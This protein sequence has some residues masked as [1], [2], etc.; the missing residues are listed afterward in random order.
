MA[1]ILSIGLPLTSKQEC[2]YQARSASQIG[3]SLGD[4]KVYVLLYSLCNVR[5]METY[6]ERLVER[7]GSRHSGRRE[8]KV[9]P[10]CTCSLMAAI[11]LTLAPLTSKQE[12]I[13]QTQSASQIDASLGSY[14][15]T[16][17]AGNSWI[18]G[19]IS[20]HI[21]KSM[22]Q[23]L[24]LETITCG[25]LC[26]NRLDEV[27]SLRLQSCNTLQD[28]LGEFLI[29]RLQ[30]LKLHVTHFAGADLCVTVPLPWVV[31]G[32]ALDT[33]GCITYILK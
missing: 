32:L 3:A 29:M 26:R 6:N 9:R 4:L 21:F 12:C 19:Q 14:V 22:P 15:P 11:L 18:C 33:I 24:T 1:A 10:S 20:T 28:R 8:C 2:I 13:Y 5:E 30:S 27:L 25:T 17:H 31:K 23:I 16:S 7:L